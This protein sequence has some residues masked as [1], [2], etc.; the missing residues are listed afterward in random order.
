VPSTWRSTD[1]YHRDVLVP[2]HPLLYWAAAV[3]QRVAMQ[4]SVNRPGLAFLWDH[5]VSGNAIVPGAAYFEMAS[6]AAGLLCR[7]P[8]QGKVAVTGAVIAAPLFLSEPMASAPVLMLMVESDA[9]MGTLAVSSAGGSHTS[10]HLRAGVT[11]IGALESSSA[12]HMSHRPYSLEVA[13]AAAPDPHAT[14]A[15][16]DGLASIGLQYGTAFR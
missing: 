16:Y 3:K 2:L 12:I 11:A 14:A 9:A 10:T 15:V 4:V 1:R 13:R 7:T 6:A 5:R 8:V